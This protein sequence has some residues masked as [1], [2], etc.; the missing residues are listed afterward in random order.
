MMCVKASNTKCC[1]LNESAFNK[2]FF[3]HLSVNLLSD[4]Q[5]SYF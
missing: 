1:F 3:S 4:C 5:Q 2:K